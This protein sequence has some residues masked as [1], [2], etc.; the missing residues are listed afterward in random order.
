MKKSLLIIACLVASLSAF[1]QGTVNFANAG[2]G[3]TAPVTNQDGSRLAGAGFQAQLLVG[4]TADS[5]TPV[6]TTGFLTG[7]GAGFFNGGVVTLSAHA[8][9]SRPFFQ[10][11]AWD[12]SSGATFDAASVR[13]QS[14][15]FQLGVTTGLG[16]GGSP[17]A[18]PAALVGLTSFQLVPEPSTIAL[19]IL[20]AGA[21]LLRR[22]K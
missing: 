13:G 2:G 1:A 17:P 7:G 14:T 18:P 9:G 16:G 6:A 4:A 8:P 10:V 22:S 5:L 21:L 19:A 15:V 20:G 3:V 11:R 12:V